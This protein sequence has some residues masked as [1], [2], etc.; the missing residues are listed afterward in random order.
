M[1]TWCKAVNTLVL[2]VLVYLLTGCSDES[3]EDFPVTYEV[4]IH[5][6]IKQKVQIIYADSTGCKSLITD[7]TWQTKVVLPPGGTA[8]LTVYPIITLNAQLREQLQKRKRT[9]HTV[10]RTR[11]I[12]TQKTVENVSLNLSISSINLTQ[13]GVA[14]IKRKR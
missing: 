14:K 13:R 12:H 9:I 1:Q 4:K 6:T 11:I 10:W 5:S 3:R 8:M 2:L 7:T